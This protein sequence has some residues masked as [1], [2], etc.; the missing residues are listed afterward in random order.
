MASTQ[1]CCC[2]AV[3]IA[4]IDM[5]VRTCAISQPTFLPWLGWF[6]LLDQV[7]V[8]VLLD[9]V[10]FSKQSWQQRN[11]I[12]TANGLE[13]L[14]VPVISSG[15]LGQLISECQLANSFFARKLLGTLQANYARAPFFKDLFPELALLFKETGE[16]TSLV[17]LNYSLIRWMVRYLGITTPMYMASALGVEGERGD[18]VAR[19]C[20]LFDSSKYISPVGAAEYLIEDKCAFDSRAIRVFLQ[21]YE[22]PEYTQCFLPFV[23]YAAALD[24]MFNAG[25]ASLEIIR[26]GRRIP[27]PIEYW[28]KKL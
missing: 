2:F 23:P 28:R 27:M 14:T 11:R 9:D 1:S 5:S 3:E 12:R 13:Y 21:G 10:S 16:G 24:L 26:S 6:D 22:H 15:K 17:E 25:P 19:I 4:R 18:H 7:D 20:E 8:F